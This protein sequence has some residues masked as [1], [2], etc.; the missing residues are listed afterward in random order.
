M[1]DILW[2]QLLLTWPANAFHH[3]VDVQPE[4]EEK[5]WQELCKISSVPVSRWYSDVSAQELVEENKMEAVAIWWAQ[6]FSSDQ[7]KQLGQYGTKVMV[8]NCRDTMIYYVWGTLPELMRDR[9]LFCYQQLAYLDLL[10]GKAQRVVAVFPTQEF[11]PVESVFCVA[12]GPRAVDIRAF[13]GDVHSSYETIGTKEKIYMLAKRPE[14]KDGFVPIEVPQAV[15]LAWLRRTFIVAGKQDYLTKE[16][17]QQSME[18][19]SSWSFDLHQKQ[20]SQV[21]ENLPS[22][23]QLV[24]PGDGIGVVARLWKGEK[25]VISG[26]LVKT[27]WSTGVNQET[28]SQTMDRALSG[29]YLILSYVLSMM[30]DQEK[31]RVR[32][33]NGPVVIIEPRETMILQGFEHVGPGVWVKGLPKMGFPQVSVSEGPMRTFTVLFSENLLALPA[34]SVLTENPAVQYWKAMR[35]NGKVEIWTP[36]SPSPLVLYT[37]SEYYFY[38]SRVKG[39]Q[40]YLAQIGRF[41]DGKAEELIMDAK[42]VI[43]VRRVYK[44]TKLNARI[45]GALKRFVSYYEDFKHFYFCCPIAKE[46]KLN[47]PGMSSEFIVQERDVP[48]HQAIWLGMNSRGIYVDVSG[49]LLIIPDTQEDRCLLK[50]YTQF[51]N[52]KSYSDVTTPFEAPFKK[53]MEK[54]LALCEAKKKKGYYFDVTVAPTKWVIMDSWVT[55]WK[56]VER[57]YSI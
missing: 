46:F 9:N 13:R 47:F 49:G 14:K 31:Q 27:P 6:R 39:A 25:P 57:A 30:S 21:L 35:P 42:N 1:E 37:L 7:L 55:H 12:T 3:L 32:V 54:L 29:D 2:S 33:W 18:H 20:V 28:F 4:G 40:V 34:I 52:V 15:K 17:Y 45:K 44:M 48:V 56:Y 5:P 38:R 53:K 51:V 26:D 8:L 50:V 43:T 11:R 19:Y 41:F 16:Y 10:I 22:D 23:A 36:S 24:A